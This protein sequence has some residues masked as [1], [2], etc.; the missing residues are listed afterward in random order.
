MVEK[1]NRFPAALTQKYLQAPLDRLI[2]LD[3]AFEQATAAA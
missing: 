1:Q 3:P 2:A